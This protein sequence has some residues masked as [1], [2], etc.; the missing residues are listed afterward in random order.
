[1][2]LAEAGPWWDDAAAANPATA[3]QQGHGQSLDVGDGVSLAQAEAELADADGLRVHLQAQ[4][5]NELRAEGTPLT[6]TTVLRRAHQLL[7]R[8]AAREVAVC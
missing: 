7:Q 1:M 5:R 2:R 8:Q 6:R 4:A 3:P